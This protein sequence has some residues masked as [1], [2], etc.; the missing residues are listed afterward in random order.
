MNRPADLESSLYA[1]YTIPAQWYTD[2]AFYDREMNSIFR[3]AWQFVGLTGLPVHAR[4][5]THLWSG[6]TTARYLHIEYAEAWP[7][8][9]PGCTAGHGDGSRAREKQG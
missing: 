3:S 6:L 5:R 9:R 4:R 7:A 1:G 2:S 8:N